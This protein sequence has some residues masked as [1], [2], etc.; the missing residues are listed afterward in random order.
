MGE[1]PY[2][3]T[4]TQLVQGPDKVASIAKTLTQTHGIDTIVTRGA[5][6]LS[7]LLYAPHEFK[8]LGLGVT[9]K[10]TAIPQFAE[11][12]IPKDEAIVQHL[13]MC[14]NT[15]HLFSSRAINPAVDIVSTHHIFA[16]AGAR[17]KA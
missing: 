6:G 3:A 8:N 9:P 14:Y 7:K 1:E 2:A 16:E 5:N 13:G 10:M 11:D 4:I 15:S 12:A 17:K